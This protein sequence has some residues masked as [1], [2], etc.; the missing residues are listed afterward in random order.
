M[1]TRRRAENLAKLDRFGR[2]VATTRLLEHRSADPTEA[3]TGIALNPVART[4]AYLLQGGLISAWVRGL[5]VHAGLPWLAKGA[6]AAGVKDN[7]IKL[8]R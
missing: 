4:T 8:S 6:V 5:V 3:G 2:R 7:A 1:I